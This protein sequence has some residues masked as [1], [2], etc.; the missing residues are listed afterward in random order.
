MM[1][2]EA[3]IGKL[4]AFVA[5]IFGSGLS[6]LGFKRLINDKT[7]KQCLFGRQPICSG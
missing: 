5:N 2:D 7:S 6:G 3:L 1:N 4:C